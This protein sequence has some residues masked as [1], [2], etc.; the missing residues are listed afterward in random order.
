MHRVATA[1]VPL[2][3]GSLIPKHTH[4]VVAN[5]T[6]LDPSIYEDPG[7]FDPFRWLKMRASA[8]TKHQAPMVS[9]GVNSLGFGYGL[10]V[11]PGRF[12]ATDLV[13]MALCHLL[14]KYDMELDQESRPKPYVPMGFF[15]GHDQ[16]V[17]IRIRRRTEEI[18]LDV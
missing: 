4:S 1:D 3:D 14:L 8:D 10:H 9:A 13:K 11:C 15:L 16:D 2:S 12:F 5:T 6:R 18:D 7:S 17:Q